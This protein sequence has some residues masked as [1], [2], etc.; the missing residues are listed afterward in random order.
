MKKHSKTLFFLNIVI[1]IFSGFSVKCFAQGKN[2]RPAPAVLVEETGLIDKG[3]GKEYIGVVEAQE[4]VDIQPRVSGFIRSINFKEGSMVKK[5]QLLVEIEDTTYK[6]KVLAAQSALE[7]AKAELEYYKSN[8]NRQKKLSAK[9]AV[10][11]SVLEDAQRQVKFHIAKCKYEKANLMDAE[12]ELS[13][14][15]IKAA[16][17][18]RI[19]E[20]NQTVGNYVSINS[21]P[22][23]KIVSINPIHVKFSISE[24]VFQNLFKEYKKA[25]NLHLKL[26]LANGDIYPHTGHIVFFDNVVD[27]ETGTISIWVE[28]DNPKKNLIPEG[29]V[30]ILL[31]E[32]MKKALP[33]VKV[34]AVLSD[35]KG[36]YVYVLD[37]NNLPQRRDIVL[38]EMVGNY[39]TVKQGLKKG[40]KT[41]VDGTHKIIPGHAVAPIETKASG[42]PA[43]QH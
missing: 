33:G 4:E 32:K 36:T 41:V 9:N 13:Y 34:S 5:G 7:Q 3:S 17:S 25:E 8:L 38:G 35:K 40:E 43:R 42:N 10:S 2:Q 30:S 27:S 22:L 21:P 29:Y 15:K 23:A 31:F 20:V 6:A 14:T 26:K 1:I 39:Y 28:F 11:D 12:N 37:K 18:G 16:I 24:R 19:G